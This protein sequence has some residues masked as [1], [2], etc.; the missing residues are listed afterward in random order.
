MKHLL[1]ISVL[2]LVLLTLPSCEREREGRLP[3]VP[4]RTE[5]AKRTSFSPTLM[6]LGVVRAAQ[7]VPIAAQQRGM[8]RYPRR[9]SAGLQTGAHVQRG[10][11]LAE[12]QNDDVQAALT[13]ARLEM[14][15]AAAA[16]D[17]AER[18]YKVGVISAA[19]HEERRVQ[20]SLA[21]EH[22]KAA[23][24]RLGT[25]RVIAPSS[26]TLVVTKVYPAG[27]IVD[28]SATLAEIASGGAPIVESSVAASERAM[29][30]PGALVT[31]ASRGT[32][33]WKGR[34]R[35]SEVAA[36]VGETGTSRVMATV[37]GPAPDSDRQRGAMAT[38]LP[39][40]PP[41]GTGVEITV[42]LEARGAVLTVP[43]DAIVAGAEGPALFIAATSEGSVDR[44]RVKR[45]PV[46]V[47]GRS[48]GRV[49]ITSG[50]HDGDRVV[51]S[52]V[53]ALT[54]DAIATEVNDKAGA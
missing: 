12:V 49:E 8:V 51:V 34:G 36:V 20:A 33:A 35:V 38:A 4:V 44:F 15:A 10:E 9:F 47:G 7:S 22:Y 21:K 31:F 27:S 26:G 42:E 30:Q 2:T 50:L 43:D 23:S 40:L 1:T 45:A 5:L 37:E 6:L 25:L 3:A 28:A 11:L 41:P 52:G 19:E 13:E 32:P 39:A 16:Y 17:R 46:V 53:D 29:I 48:N 18:S 24:T 54:D 14:D